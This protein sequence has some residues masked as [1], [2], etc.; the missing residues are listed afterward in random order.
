MISRAIVFV[1]FLVADFTFFQ[2]ATA[3]D[4]DECTT[5]FE[6]TAKN[7]KMRLASKWPPSTDTLM[8]AQHDFQLLTGICP[9]ISHSYYNLAMISFEFLRQD[10]SIAE[11]L[12]H[13]AVALNR[14][15]YLPPYAWISI[16]QGKWKQAFHSLIDLESIRRDEHTSHIDGNQIFTITS[17]A[18]VW[19]DFC[20]NYYNLDTKTIELCRNKMT[21]VLA[22]AE[23]QGS[24]LKFRSY[25]LYRLAA[26][27]DKAMKN[28]GGEALAFKL[29]QM[30]NNDKWSSIMLQ[31]QDNTKFQNLSVAQDDE[32]EEE[33]A[34]LKEIFLYLAF[35]RKMYDGK[36]SEDIFDFDNFE[37]SMRDSNF[38]CTPKM[39]FILGMPRSGTSLMEKILCSHSKIH[40]LG[41]SSLITDIVPGISIK[42]SNKYQPQFLEKPKLALLRRKFY[43]K[44]QN[45]VR[46][47][48]PDLNLELGCQNSSYIYFTDKTPQN[49]RYVPFIKALFPDSP[50]IH[51]MR[52]PRDVF[53]SVFLNDFRSSGMVWSLKEKYI[54]EYYK[55]YLETMAT[56]NRNNV[57]MIDVSYES[58]VENATSTVKSIL[59]PKASIKH[60]CTDH[61][62]NVDFEEKM[63]EFYK[64]TRYTHTVSFLQV[65]QKLTRKFCGRWRRYQSFI[66]EEIIRY[67]SFYNKSNMKSIYNL[68]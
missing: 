43:L 13:Q 37:A 54:R 30:A 45:Y 3:N 5:L 26:Y 32:A 46:T 2:F 42:K 57:S 25:I 48:S 4:H 61:C 27:Y 18:A 39:I 10:P 53:V 8:S 44:V 65:Q 52:D 23:T 50:I 29:A 31:Y 60:E 28:T 56:W 63:L 11:K 64:N 12:L 22:Q 49:I 16:R 1:I 34:I 55:Q 35:S 14:R 68:L 17:S 58:L 47:V 41:E 59:C 66:P 40:C 67:G 19:T 62:V 9:L 15:K 20:S 33:P 51:M 36:S 21:S 7:V 6:E 24:K 38:S